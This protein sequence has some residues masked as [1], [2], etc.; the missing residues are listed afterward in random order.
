MNTA[1]NQVAYSETED[2]LTR[3]TKKVRIMFVDNDLDY[4]AMIELASRTQHTFI[5]IENGGISA[6]GKLAKMNYDVDA[7]VTDLAMRDMDG[8]TLTEQIRRNEKIRRKER[9]IDIYWFTGYDYDSNDPNDPITRASN[10]N[11]IKKVFVKPYDVFLIFEEVKQQVIA[12]RLSEPVQ[13]G[14]VA[15]GD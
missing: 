5:A 6:L 15:N 11:E 7:I 13:T 8:I 10:M 9:P 3:G 4:L 2:S 12:S 14:S 1:S